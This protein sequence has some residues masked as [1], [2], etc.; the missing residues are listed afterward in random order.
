MTPA[1]TPHWTTEFRDGEAVLFWNC[2]RAAVFCSALRGHSHTRSEHDQSAL[3]VAD[4]VAAK[5]NWHDDLVAA[6][7]DCGEA[8]EHWSVLPADKAK[9]LRKSI[10]DALAKVDA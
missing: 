1:P 6:L 7:R 10:R 9:A 8:L 5:L 4:A 3:Q 2:G